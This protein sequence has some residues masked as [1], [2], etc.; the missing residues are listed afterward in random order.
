MRPGRGRVHS[1]SLG[2]FD[3]ARFGLSGSILTRPRRGRVHSGSFG[4]FER[5]LGVVLFIQVRH[6]GRRVYSGA[7]WGTLGSFGSSWWSSGSFGLVPFIRARQAIHRVHSGSF[8]RVLA[9]IWIRRVHSGASFVSFG[10]ALEI[11]GYIQA[12]PVCR[13][14]HSSSFGSFVRA[15]SVVG[16]IQFRLVVYFGWMTPSPQPNEPNETE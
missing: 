1:D 9:M 4:Y 14:V 15:L 7:P 2:S 6:V 10:S 11:V 5:A 12:R 3:R 8:M 16:Y 13:R